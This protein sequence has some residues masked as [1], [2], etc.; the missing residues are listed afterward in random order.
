[1]RY[2]A[3]EYHYRLYTHIYIFLTNVSLTARLAARKPVRMSAGFVKRTVPE[4][5][6]DRDE[7]SY[8]EYYLSRPERAA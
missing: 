7:R 1:M 4:I 3:D 2:T 8:V 6:S 5:R